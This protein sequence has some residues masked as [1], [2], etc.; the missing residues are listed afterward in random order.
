M[1]TVSMRICVFNY[2]IAL[3]DKMSDTIHGEDIP[4]NSAPFLRPRWVTGSA[5]LLQSQ[6]T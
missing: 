2:I 6:K 3:Q 1:K 4:K 5:S